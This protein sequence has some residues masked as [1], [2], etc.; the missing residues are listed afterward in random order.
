MSHTVRIVLIVVGVVTVLGGLFAWSIEDSYGS[1]LDYSLMPEDGRIQ[2]FEASA[3]EEP[4]FVG[5][6]E[7]AN[8]YMQRQR[9]ARESFVLPGAIIA[10]GVIMV[11]VGAFVGRRTEPATE[12]STPSPA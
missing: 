8:G 5:T 1:G 7:E 10:A 3:G 11:L 6:R 4:V 12:A 2:V 9:A